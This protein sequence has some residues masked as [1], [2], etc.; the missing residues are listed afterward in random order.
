MRSRRIGLTVLLPVLVALGC[1]ASPPAFEPIP[2]LV[3]P[4]VFADPRPQASLEPPAPRLNQRATLTGEG[5]PTDASLE[6]WLSPQ[7]AG[8]FKM[9]ARHP[10]GFGVKLGD[11]RTDAQGRFSF[12]FTAIDPQPSAHNLP[13]GLYGLWLLYPDGR[14][15]A[16]YVATWECPP[17]ATVQGRLFD[18]EGRPVREA[19]RVTVRAY[20]SAGQLLFERAVDASD[21]AY[22]VEEVPEPS[23]TEIAVTREGWPTRVRREPSSAVSAQWGSMRTSAEIEAFFEKV[24]SPVSFDF[25]GTGS[26]SDPWAK[27]FSLS[28][29]PAGPTTLRGRVYD[30]SGEA[31]VDAE[32]AIVIATELVPVPGRSP[33]RAQGAVRG[34]AYEIE[35]VPAAT[36]LELDL[37]TNPVYPLSGFRAREVVL[38]PGAAASINFGGPATSEDPDASAHPF[39]ASP[40]PGSTGPSPF[41]SP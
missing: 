27:A 7:L 41:P 21:G 24:G 30:A 5:A 1:D 22:R 12:S 32:G 15:V 4:Y 16:P 35:G 29:E 2:L 26:E 19:A 25:G 33:F 6:V 13:L 37:R 34:G 3:S 23:T 11:A 28:S 20:N 17:P 8:G 18:A 31:V 40:A 36:H 9:G 10:N 38:V 39:P 14:T